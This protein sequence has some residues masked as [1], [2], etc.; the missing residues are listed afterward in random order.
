MP[1]PSRSESLNKLPPSCATAG[2]ND[3]IGVLPKSGEQL[4]ADNM[5]KKPCVKPITN[6]AGDIGELCCGRPL[7]SGERTHPVYPKSSVEDDT[8]PIAISVMP[9]VKIPLSNPSTAPN[10]KLAQRGS[11]GRFG[12]T[13]SIATRR[14]NSRPRNKTPSVRPHAY[15]SKLP[16]FSRNPTVIGSHKAKANAPAITTHVK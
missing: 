7:D 10:D 4:P 13:K 8:C 9:M 3:A 16:P 5:L 14:I 12:V 1:R 2:R 11:A 6:D 15:P